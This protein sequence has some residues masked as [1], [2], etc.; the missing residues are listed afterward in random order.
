MAAA[1]D[2]ALQMLYPQSGYLGKYGDMCTDV[3]VYYSLRSCRVLESFGIRLA[4]TLSKLMGIF[5]LIYENALAIWRAI[6]LRTDA[7]TES[8]ADA[9]DRDG[10]NNPLY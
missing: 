9:A 10:Q 8:F 2:F 6:N 1:V 7:E 3:R 4:L 5:G